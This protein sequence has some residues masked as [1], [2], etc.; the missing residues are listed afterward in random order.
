MPRT[1]LMAFHFTQISKSIGTSTDASAIV[2][3]AALW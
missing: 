1:L 2:A 3:F